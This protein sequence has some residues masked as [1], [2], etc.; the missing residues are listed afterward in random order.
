MLDESKVN[1]MLEQR[2]NIVSLLFVFEEVTPEAARDL[3]ESLESAIEHNFGHME[4]I[5]ALGEAQVKDE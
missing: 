1:I 3:I 5:K 2:E 4:I